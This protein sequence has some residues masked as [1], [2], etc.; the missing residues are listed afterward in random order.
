MHRRPPTLVPP[1]AS[2]QP[3]AASRQPPAASRQPPAASRQ[4]PFCKPSGP[5]C[6]LLRLM[7]MVLSSPLVS[8]KWSL[9][10]WKLQNRSFRSAAPV[11]AH[12]APHRRPRRLEHSHPLSLMRFCPL[13][14]ISPC[15]TSHLPRRLQLPLHFR[16]GVTRCGSLTFSTGFFPKATREPWR[17]ALG[18]LTS[19]SFSFDCHFMFFSCSKECH[20]LAEW[21]LYLVRRGS[22]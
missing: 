2:R 4:P 12:L 5:R 7:L 18:L 9:K 8:K 16:I 3:P 11:L 22:M 17:S 21:G 6:H 19:D 1:A 13:S 20:A 10:R 15:L 14:Q